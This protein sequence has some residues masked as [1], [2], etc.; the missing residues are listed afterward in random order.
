MKVKLLKKLRRI[1]KSEIT[2][3]SITTTDGITTGMSY[4]YDLDCYKGLFSMGDTE[5]D[6]INKVF[7]IY[8]C[9]NIEFIRKKYKKYSSNFTN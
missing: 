9:N 6:V 7:R 3:L 4:G 8:L 2:I 5:G 1:A